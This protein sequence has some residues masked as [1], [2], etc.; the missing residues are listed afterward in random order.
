MVCPSGSDSLVLQMKATKT[1][2][3]A[4]GCVSRDDIKVMGHD[5]FLP[6]ID[7]LCG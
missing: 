3:A 5:D 7:F 2:D 6:G 4:K 1:I